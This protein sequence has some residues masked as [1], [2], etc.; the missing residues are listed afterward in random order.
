M[1]YSP[2]DFALISGD[3]ARALFEYACLTY[4]VRHLQRAFE[5]DPSLGP[6]NGGDINI[7]FQPK[8]DEDVFE[9]KVIEAETHTFDKF[10]WIQ[11]LAKSK[12]QGEMAKYRYF[13]SYG[14]LD[15][16]SYS[17][18]TATVLMNS[19]TNQPSIRIGEVVKR[20][21]VTS[22]REQEPG[23]MYRFRADVQFQ[24]PTAVQSLGPIDW[25]SYWK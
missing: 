25:D 5:K 11:W 6:R 7:L 24:R 14:A 21:R 8:V 20:S 2:E 10:G 16:E 13:N 12:G 19:R 4:S 18:R 17:S 1:N 3:S 15:V 22:I 9:R 23:S